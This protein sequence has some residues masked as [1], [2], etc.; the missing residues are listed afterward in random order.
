MT[1]ME[2]KILILV[3][4]MS[5]HGGFYAFLQSLLPF[6]DKSGF[7]IYLA[8]YTNDI[9]QEGIKDYFPQYKIVFLPLPKISNGFS[10]YR[11]I[12]LV[13]RYDISILFVHDL[14]E[15]ILARVLKIFFS[16][17]KCYATIHSN[18]RDMV[19]DKKIVKD[20]IFTINRLTQRLVDRYICVSGYI[21]KSLVDQGVSILRTMV[22]YNGIY[23][24]KKLP[25]RHYNGIRNIGFI[26]RLSYEKGI[27]VFIRIAEE[28]KNLDINFHIY[29]DGPLQSLVNE[30]IHRNNHLLYH[31]TTHHKEQIYTSLD[32]TILPSRSEGM[33]YT[34]LESFLYGVVV[35]AN[36]AGGLPE[37]V[38]GN[39]VLIKNN[40]I[41]DYKE[42]IKVLAK[43][44][45][46]GKVFRQNGY[47]FLNEKGDIEKIGL[48]YV[49]LFING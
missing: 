27:D 5:P 42:A 34:V 30:A 10:I 6:L 17:I 25:V 16:N 44:F 49:Q 43:D 48:E 18:L 39:G 3:R 24:D 41:Q 23:V 36:S 40:N 20:F 21:Q 47:N 11:L 9:Y 26:G 32:I 35:I 28:C 29:G 38:R 14:F 33:P 19:G 4:L 13:R 45:E 37:V 7:D 46:S 2:R 8:I 15:S 1:K 22:I 12:K 31:R